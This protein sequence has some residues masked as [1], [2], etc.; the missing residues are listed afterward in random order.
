MGAY[1]GHDIN[2]FSPQALKLR[3]MQPSENNRLHLQF[4][5]RFARE[6]LNEKVAMSFIRVLLQWFV[7][8]DETRMQANLCFRSRG[9]S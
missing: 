8:H 5:G 1:W 4:S 6:K 9:E 7:E 3:Q 2:S